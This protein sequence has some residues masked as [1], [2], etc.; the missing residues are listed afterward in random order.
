MDIRQQDNEVISLKFIIISYL[1]YWGLFLAAFCVSLIFAILYLVFY[2]TTYELKARFKI[3]DDT[4]LSSGNMALGD[5]A[6]L[7]KSFGLSGATNG[8]ITIDDELAVLESH[9]VW[10]DVVKRLGLNAEYVEPRTWNYKIYKDTPF[11]MMADSSTLESQEKDIEFHIKN[12][13]TGKVKVDAKSKD[14]K[15]SYDIESLPATISF[16]KDRFVLSHGPAYT[17]GQSAEL[18]ITM[19]PAGFVGDDLAKNIEMDTYSDNSST[20][21]CAFRDYE[22]QRGID[23]L[24]T[25][26]DIYNTRADSIKDKDAFKTITFLDGRIHKVISE[27]SEVERIIER[28]KKDNKMTDLE[29]DVQF[30]VDQMKELQS[31]IVELEGQGH[32]IRFMEEFVQDPANKYNL[33]PVLMSVQEG[34]KGSSISSYNELLIERQRMLQNSKEDNPLF[35][36]MDKQLNQMRNSVCLTIKNA[37]NSLALTLKDLKSKE[38]E[39]L[40][41]MGD[42]PSQERQYI[43]YKREQEIAQGVYLI[44]LQKREEAML[45]MGKALD[46]A[47]IV[48]AGYA[49][50]IP[51]A[52][53]KLYAALAMMLFTIAFPVIYLFCRDRIVELK[54]EYYRT[55]KQMN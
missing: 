44:L 7:M 50:S 20:I 6:G 53:R 5:A 48:D 22:R 55:K 19:R 52:P 1:R 51:V 37:Q 15:Q 41:K 33:V 24:N 17:Q 11:I 12:Y 4:G 18:Y 46:R 47:L 8:A 36:V 49:E 2:P 14:H 27:L 25:L 10:L 28:Y 26:I 35:A 42:V 40:S 30:Y 23:I 21:D 29:H 34:E 38:E 16:G 54:E 32:A 3:Q 39:I 13:K 45:Q 31:K 9:S 43:N